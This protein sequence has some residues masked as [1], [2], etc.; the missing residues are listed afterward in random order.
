MP[1]SAMYYGL[2][3]NSLQPLGDMGNMTP[4]GTHGQDGLPRSLM[5]FP[6]LLWILNYMGIPT[7]IMNNQIRMDAATYQSIHFTG[8]AGSG[9]IRGTEE[10][11]YIAMNVGLYAYKQYKK[12]MNNILSTL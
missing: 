10:Q 12:F 3:N 7:S 11:N 4:D 8:N 6:I 2:K 9:A 5:A 1:G